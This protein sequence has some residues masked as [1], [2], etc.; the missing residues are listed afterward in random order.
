MC[1]ERKKKKEKKYRN[2]K[3][4]KINIVIVSHTGNQ[5]TDKTC[6][7]MDELLHMEVHVFNDVIQGDEVTNSKK[8]NLLMMSGLANMNFP[9]QHWCTKYSSSH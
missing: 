5:N 3:R 4:S 8:E 6:S 1:N 7:V 2:W 9:L